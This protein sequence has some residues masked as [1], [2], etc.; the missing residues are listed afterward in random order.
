VDRHHL[1][2]VAEFQRE[3]Q[4]REEQ[5]CRDRQDPNHAG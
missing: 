5:A 4:Y 1:F 2:S 3:W